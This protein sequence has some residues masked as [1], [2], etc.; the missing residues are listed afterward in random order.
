MAP[1]S[2]ILA[3][4]TPWADGPGGLQ[5]MGHRR[6]DTIEDKQQQRI[7]KDARQAAFSS[8]PVSTLTPLQSILYAV[9]REIL[10]NQGQLK[11]LLPS[12]VSHGSVSLPEEA[13]AL[14]TAHRPYATRLTSWCL[15]DFILPPLSAYVAPATLAFLPFF[16]H[17]H[18]GCCSLMTLYSS[19]PQ[20]LF[21]LIE[22]QLT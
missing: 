14:A 8:D 9:I 11:S 16:R 13:K 6:S 15:S 1:H 20:S 4:K 7:P 21:S 22:I 10:L 2:S 17:V 3:W 12:K 5:S 18:Q 19:S